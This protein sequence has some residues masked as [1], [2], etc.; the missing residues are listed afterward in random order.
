M[1]NSIDDLLPVISFGQK[2]DSD[3][4]VKHEEFV[5]RM[6]KRGYTDRQVRRLVEWFMRVQKSG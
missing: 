6:K 5:V 1:F 3:M 2:K 4:E